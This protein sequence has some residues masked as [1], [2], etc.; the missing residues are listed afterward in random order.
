[1]ISL[2]ACA[3]VDHHIEA[4]RKGYQKFFLL[5]ESV[6][7]AKHATG[8]I[9]NPISASYV[10]WHMVATLDKRQIAAFVENLW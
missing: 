10:K 2:L 7:V 1:M 6:A 3:I 5:T 8:H 9:V 4:A